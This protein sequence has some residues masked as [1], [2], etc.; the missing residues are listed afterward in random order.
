MTK[1][2]SQDLYITRIKHWN[3]SGSGPPPSFI[4]TLWNIGILHHKQAKLRKD[5][6]VQHSV[7]VIFRRHIISISILILGA[8]ILTLY[9]KFHIRNTSFLNKQDWRYFTFML[10][11]VRTAWK[12]LQESFHIDTKFN[13]NLFQ[14]SS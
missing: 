4:P 13:E 11:A 2:K 8:K 12:V 9:Y 5:M 3:Y 10:A 7:I 14:N 6:Q 1:F